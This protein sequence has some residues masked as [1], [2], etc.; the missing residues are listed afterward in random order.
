MTYLV[1]TNV[2]VYALDTREPERQ[3]RALG[4]LRYLGEQDTGLLSTQ[5]LSELA[6]VCLHRLR[7]RWTPQQIAEHIGDLSLAMEVL[8]ITPAVVREALRGVQEHRMSFYD[9]QMWATAR[10]N[11]VPC[12]LTQ[13]MASD[14]TIDGVMILDPFTLPPP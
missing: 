10:L 12:L 14:A 13:D 9:A 2:L 11:Q 6:N 4:W 7:P 5:A 8:P 3:A 1:D